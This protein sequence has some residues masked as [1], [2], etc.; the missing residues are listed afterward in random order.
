MVLSTS[1]SKVE[2]GDGRSRSPTNIYD[3]FVCFFPYLELISSTEM[4]TPAQVDDTLAS[5]DAI[6]ISLVV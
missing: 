2:G 6:N 1:L 3:C 5:T 4:N